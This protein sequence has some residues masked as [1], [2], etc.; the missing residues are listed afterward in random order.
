MAL[1]T[2][3]NEYLVLTAPELRFT[4]G[5]QAVVNFRIKASQRK[6]NETTNQWEDDKVFFATAIA[7]REKAEEIANTIREK[8]IVTI[9]GRISTREYEGKNGKGVAVELDVDSIGKAIKGDKP[10]QG[11]AQQPYGQQQQ[12]YQQPYGQQPP[13]QQPYGQQPP[14]Q[15]QPYGAPQTQPYQQQP[16]QWPEQQQPAPGVAPF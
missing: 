10:Q 5:G 6:K 2:G 16:G 13:V 4:P 15:Q 1:P 8:D 9:A 11:Q 14:A 12:P 3:G 7:W